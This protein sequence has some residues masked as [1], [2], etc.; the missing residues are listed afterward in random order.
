MKRRTRLASLPPLPSLA[1]EAGVTGF[2]LTSKSPKTLPSPSASLPFSLL[3]LASTRM[4][5]HAPQAAAILSQAAAASPYDKSSEAS[6]DETTRELEVIATMPLS[7]E[8]NE[9]K[10]E[11]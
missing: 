8:N 4:G 11:V 2:M 3:L 5:A 9:E 7:G 1:T 10:R 6:L